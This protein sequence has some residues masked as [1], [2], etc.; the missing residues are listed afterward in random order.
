VARAV[1]SLGENER[2]KAGL[3]LARRLV[4]EIH[5]AVVQ[6][7]VEPDQLIDTGEVLQAIVRRRPDGTPETVTGPLIPLLDTTLLTNAPGEPRIG[8]QLVT[9]IES[10]DA[11]STV[12]AFIR[13]SG[14]RPLIDALK[15]HCTA[16]KP[17]RVLT[18]IYT[19]STEPRALDALVELGAK[20]RV[21]YD[22]TA[23]RLH[24]KG[25]MFE[26]HSGFCTAYIGSSNLTHSAQQD[27]LEWNVSG[28]ADMTPMA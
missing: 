6:A 5:S 3:A 12:M 21:S 18:T 25:W 8:S 2:A 24:A 15:D 10:A 14:L 17:L 4:A 22:T 26:R 9:E 13:Y 7:G 16:G 27:G 23:T 20:V 11:I 19:G 1:G 28:G